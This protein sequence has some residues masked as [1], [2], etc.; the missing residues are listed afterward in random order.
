MS[1][2]T[3]LK[4]LESQQHGHERSH[5]PVVLIYRCGDDVAALIQ[6][7]TVCPCCSVHVVLPAK[8]SR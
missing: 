3:R 5:T 8:G 4:R 1:L 2:D 6:Q 7:A